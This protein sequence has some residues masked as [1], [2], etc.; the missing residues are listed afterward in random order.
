MNKWLNLKHTEKS[1][2]KKQLLSS[3][4]DY[5]SRTETIACLSSKASIS[6]KKIRKYDEA[7]ISYGFTWTG[8]KNE[9]RALFV[10]CGKILSNNSLNSDKLKRHLEAIHPSLKHS[11]S[12]EQY[13]KRKC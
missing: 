12:N 11:K 13:F 4:D 8:D 5:V 3:T 9:P 6:K 7:F 10:E 2:A 1:N